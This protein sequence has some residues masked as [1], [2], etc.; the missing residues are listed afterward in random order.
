VQPV[1]KVQ[2]LAFF[3]A[4]LEEVI[5]AALAGTLADRE[6]AKTDDALARA[7]YRTDGRTA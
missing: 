3:A 5:D 2:G 1:S 7:T 4:E 6:A